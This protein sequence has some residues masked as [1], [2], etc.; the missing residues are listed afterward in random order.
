MKA[1]ARS[2]RQLLKYPSAIA[3]AFLIIL[4]IAVSI[5]T[6]I[7]IPYADAIRLWRGGEDIWGDSPRTARPLWLDWITAEKKS[8][9]IVIDS[10]VEAHGIEKTVTEVAKD[11]WDIGMVYE[12]DYPYDGF[13]QEM[14]V[15][16]KATYS[17]KN[18]F[19]SM[20]WETPDGRQ[21][22]MSDTDLSPSSSYRFDQDNRLARRL[23][24]GLLPQVALFAMP[25]VDPP[26]TV[27]GTYR[28]YVDG[29]VFEDGSDF[30]AKLVLFGEVHGLFGTDHRRRDMTVP[31]LW[32][33]PIALTFGLIASLGTTVLT[34]LIA[35]TGVWYG[36]L[37]DDLIQRITE[38]NILLPLLPIL[39]M[40]GTFYNRS[41]WTMLGLIIVLSIFGAG[42]KNY[43][44]IFLQIKEAPYIEAA[45]S[46]GAGN[47]RIIVKYLIPRII[48]ILIPGLVSGIP[49]FVFL[50]ASLAVLGLGDPVLPTWGKLIND[51]QTQGALNNG[52]YYWVLQPA[53]LLMITGL[54]F[55]MVG[56]ALDRIFNP[57]LREV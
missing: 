32:G 57:R 12:F 19:V 14:I 55:A 24:E 7:A 43:R 38:I 18:P 15:Y 4:L 31:L 8:Q 36:G 39:I 54:G 41:I 23:P 11:M 16:F 29:I 45:R 35:A 25:E 56:F 49:A 50:E 46:Y 53:V 26:T 20:T 51:A 22:R 9:T 3:G 33:T 27:K 52:Y 28:L 10:A 42:I 34:M 40:V 6:L 44:A 48:P 5:Y 17:E 21:F 1:I 2:F 47:F 30:D 13:P 37:V